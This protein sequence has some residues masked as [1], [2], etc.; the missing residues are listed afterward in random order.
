V[1]VPGQ[2][3]STDGPLLMYPGLAVERRGGYAHRLSWD[4]PAFADDDQERAWVIEQVTAA[5]DATVSAAGAAAPVVI[6]KSLGSLS[7]PVVADR[8][9]AAVWLTPVLTD[10]PTVSALRAAKGPCLLVGGTADQVWDGRTARL[11]TPY[12][13]E[14]EDA[15]HGMLVPG[16]LS[17][18]A[19]VLG[20][21]I[22]AVEDFLDRV[23]WPA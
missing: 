4:V 8:G 11:I 12:V 3:Y 20:Q 10:E 17:A 9:L 7:A 5:I 19:A 6:G 22:T 2:R 15:D 16:A 13:L 14:V 23:A 1:L 18:S 21:V